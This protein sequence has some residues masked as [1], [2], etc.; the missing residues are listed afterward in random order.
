MLEKLV[1]H[2]EHVLLKKIYSMT[3]TNFIL[4]ESPFSHSFTIRM[5]LLLFYHPYCSYRVRIE[6]MLI[7]EEFT[8]TLDWLKPAIDA[9]IITARDLQ[10]SKSLHEVLY[11]VLL[12]GNYLNAVSLLFYACY[13]ITSSKRLCC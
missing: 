9:I 7:K 2:G 4:T 8:Q 6:A 13:L 1:T 11:M 12:A 3:L 10:E 5:Y